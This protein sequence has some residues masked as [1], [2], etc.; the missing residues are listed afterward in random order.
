[1]KERPI[2]LPFVIPL[3]VLMLIFS[4]Q[5]ALA[6]DKKTVPS[7]DSLKTILEE[8]QKI[9]EEGKK[10]ATP[11]FQLLWA[12]EAF[13]HGNIEGALKVW[14]GLAEQGNETAQYVLM[15]FAPL[16]KSEEKK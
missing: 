3:A 2:G 13:R 10:F 12:R 9:E 11:E 8:M 1:M 15:L 5:S 6:E 7:Q 16:E 14:F 4:L